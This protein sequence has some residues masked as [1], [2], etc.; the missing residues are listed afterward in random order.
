MKPLT[1]EW[2]TKAEEDFVREARSRCKAFRKAARAVLSL[3]P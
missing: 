2:V 3:E 1:A